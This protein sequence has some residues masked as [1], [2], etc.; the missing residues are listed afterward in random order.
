MDNVQ[1]NFVI[2]IVVSVY[3]YTQTLIDASKEISLV[4]NTERTKYML[5]SRH[6]NA[7]QNHVLKIGLK[8]WR[9]SD[10]WERR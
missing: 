4:V 8:M 10:I 9:S 5:L 6:Q 2:N 3:V 1:H 7:G